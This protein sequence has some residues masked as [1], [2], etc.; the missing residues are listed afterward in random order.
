MSDEDRKQNKTGETETGGTKGSCIPERSR[1]YS[2]DHSTI[3]G[4]QKLAYLLERMNLSQ[5]LE[6]MQNKNRIIWNNLIAGVARGFGF[7]I[8]MTLLAS[9]LLFLLGSIV[10]MP[11]IGRYVAKIVDIVQQR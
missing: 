8:G 2:L 5:Y 3:V 11:L 6:M 9:F 7:T 10:D 1:D 4:L